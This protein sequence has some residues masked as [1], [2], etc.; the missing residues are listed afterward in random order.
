[1]PVQVSISL[2]VIT[3]AVSIMVALFIGII[4]GLLCGIK[5]IQK[6][7]NSKQSIRVPEE[8]EIRS[9][10]GP[11]YEEVEL[12]DKMNTIDLSQNI[13]YEQVKKMAS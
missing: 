4:L 7:L 11:V 5:Y 1:M 9:M 13:A 12:E 8:N 3:V 10:K 6:K 2:L